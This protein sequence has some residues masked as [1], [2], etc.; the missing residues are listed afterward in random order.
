MQIIKTK[1]YLSSCEKEYT[2][3]SLYNKDKFIYCSG[4]CYQQ[5]FKQHM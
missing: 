2:L 4:K 1:C 3:D 5:A